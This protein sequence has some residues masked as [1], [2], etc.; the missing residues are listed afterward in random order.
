MMTVSFIGVV[1]IFILNVIGNSL[2]TMK[3]I[4]VAKKLLRPAYIIVFLEAAVFFGTIGEIAKDNNFFY[5][6]AFALGKTAG[7][8]VGNFFENKMALGILEISVFAKNEKAKIIADEL[9]NIGYSVTNYKGFGINGKTRYEMKITIKRKELS[10]LKKI[11]AKYGY[12]EATMVIRE[13]NSV[14]GKISISK[15]ESTT[16]EK[17]AHK[18]SEKSRCKQ[19]VWRVD[20]KCQ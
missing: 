17:R 18:S 11:L 8:W 16:G 15:N 10:L 13:V 3:T 2:S 12:D 6:I 14:M 7:T 1:L 20:H 19:R 9:R 5:L 4:F